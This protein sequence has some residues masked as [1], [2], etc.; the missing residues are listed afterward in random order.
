[1]TKLLAIALSAFFIQGAAAQD[2][3]TR[4]ITI[5][6]PVPPGGIV[7]MAAR[8]ASE[9]LTQALHQSVVVDNRTGA[10]G[11]IAYGYVAQA[12]HD[13]YTLLASYSMYHAGNP[14]LFT[15]MRWNAKSFSPVAMVAVAPHVVVVHPS[16][17]VHSLKELVA[18][19][20]AHPGEVNYASQGSG[21]VPHVGTELLKQM[22]AT[23]MVHVPYKGSGPAIQD[24]L[25]GRVQ[26]FITTPPSVIG[27]I[28]Q[29]KLRA[30]AVASASRHPM[31]PDVP[32]SAEQGFANF[33]L[34]AWVSLFAPAGTPQAVIDKLAGALEIG[35]AKPETIEKAR[36]AGIEVRYQSPQELGKT[37]E[38]DTKHWSA[39]IKSA[40]IVAN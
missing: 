17:P 13:G 31:L 19:A 23:D 40:G 8:L 15:D 18:Y 32:T 9:P 38:A 3:P 24:V 1:M 37:V 21:S 25:S 29:G 36:A 35:L 14:S 34:D 12:A 10:S 33:E 16:L 11:N 39:V 22:T 30:I 4:P 6:V 7:D 5:V 26:L 27:H 20:K 2:F 28:Q